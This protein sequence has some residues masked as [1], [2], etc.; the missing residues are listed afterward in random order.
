M[1]STLYVLVEFVFDQHDIKKNIYTNCV[2]KITS[3][4][5]LYAC[6]TRFVHTRR[7][8]LSIEHV[9]TVLCTQNV[10]SC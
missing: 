3:V 1:L 10:S 5:F 4:L 8:L 6:E 7:E 9:C 2:V